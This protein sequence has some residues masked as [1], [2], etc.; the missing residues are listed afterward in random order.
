[1]QERPEREGKVKL[2][3]RVAFI[4]STK[5]YKTYKEAGKCGLY[6]GKEVASRN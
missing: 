5:N 6:T 2:I 4:L 3:G 1:M